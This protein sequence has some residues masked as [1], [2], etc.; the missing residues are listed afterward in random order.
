VTGRTKKSALTHCII[1]GKGRIYGRKEEAMSAV[2][3]QRASTPNALTHRLNDYM[4]E[5]YQKISKRAFS[6]FEENGH[7]HGHDLDHWLTAESEFLCPAPLEIV[8]TDTEVTVR[9]D[10]PGF[11]EKELEI[12]AEPVRL[13]ITGKCETKTDQNNKKTVYSEISFREV[14]R[15]IALPA[16]IDPEKVTALLKNG[17]LEISLQ[18]TEPAKKIPVLAKAA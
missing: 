1:T 15:S 18:K 10:V 12:V 4:N 7:D 9:A 3:V 6:I 5:L 16:K 14:F 8:E 13:F 2:A 17:V 11:T